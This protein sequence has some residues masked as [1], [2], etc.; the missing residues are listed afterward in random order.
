[1][2]GGFRGLFAVIKLI[3]LSGLLFEI[4][5][6]VIPCQ[7]QLSSYRTAYQKQFNAGM[8]C[9]EREVRLKNYNAASHCY[10]QCSAWEQ[11][12]NQPDLGI[13]WPWETWHEH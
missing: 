4:L 5:F 3:M 12:N 8:N 10:D 7:R 6:F 13:Y 11:R 2:A 1:M 9:W